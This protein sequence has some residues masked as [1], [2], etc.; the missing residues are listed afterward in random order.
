M[1]SVLR[2]GVVA[3]MALGLLLPATPVHAEHRGRAQH[4]KCTVV[5][6]PGDDRLRGTERRDVICGLGGNDRIRGA[7][8]DVL[9]GGS[10][11]DELVSAGSDVL[12]GG[13][14]DDRLVGSR[15]AD[16]LVGGTGDDVL[17]GSDAAD[18]MLG[19]PGNDVLRGDRGQDFLLGGRG[20]DD[21]WSGEARPGAGHDYCGDGTRPSACAG[22]DGH[23]PVLV[24]ATVS[25]PEIDVSGGGTFVTLRAHIR[26]DVGVASVHLE[27]HGQDD[28]EVMLGWPLLPVFG[29]NTRARLTGPARDGVWTQ[30]ISVPAY[31]VPDAYRMSVTIAPR[32]GPLSVVESSTVLTIHNDHPDLEPPE[33]VS[34]SAPA[35]VSRSAPPTV[36]LR[37]TDDLAGVGVV[38]VCYLGVDQDQ[39]QCS[40]GE[41][42]NGTGRDG[43]WG[44]TL[45]YL[46]L[47]DLG[48][49]RF[50]VSMV[51]NADRGAVLHSA[52]EWAEHGIYE[53]DIPDGHLLPD[54]AGDFML[55]P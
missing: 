10:G 8:R 16:R 26:D 21:L 19:G 15:H 22:D 46:D 12:F 39:A 28:S 24:S 35:Q 7:Y 44:A 52:S 49:G 23:P 36:T 42:A 38:W 27:L 20:D 17:I 13:P 9:V 51:D 2:L 18:R 25:R 1:R 55:V 40:P 50:Y 37:I 53:P 32:V 33:L 5:G 11:D 29:L 3:T 6:T 43:I 30:R 48:P 47:V 14:G 45:Q 4:P 31:Q 34:M 54:G 41:L